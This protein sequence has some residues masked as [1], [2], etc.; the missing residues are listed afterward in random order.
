M[1]LTSD[2]SDHI[3][4][5]E[6]ATMPLLSRVVLTSALT[7]LLLDCLEGGDG[8]NGRGTWDTASTTFTVVN[9]L[10]TDNNTVFVYSLGNDSTL[11]HNYTE[12]PT[13]TESTTEPAANEVDVTTLWKYIRGAAILQYSPP[14]LIVMATVGNIMSVITLQHPTFRKS[15]TSFMLSALA[16][17][18]ALM[19]VTGCTRQWLRFTFDLDVRLLSPF[20]CNLHI[21]LVYCLPMVRVY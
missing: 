6:L 8:S 3:C 15:S 10:V 5:E 12:I 14:F 13:T 9:H 17:V 20:G 19:V 18:D 4:R 16:I 11:S 2:F 7:L 1:S 21:F